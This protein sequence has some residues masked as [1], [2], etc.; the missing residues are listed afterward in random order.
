MS[1]HIDYVPKQFFLVENIVEI[2]KIKVT[3]K[4]YQTEKNAFQIESKLVF[5]NKFETQPETDIDIV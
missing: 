1:S 2:R 4:F 5:R 3:Y